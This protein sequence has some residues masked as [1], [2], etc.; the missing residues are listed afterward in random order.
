MSCD[1][2][3]DTSDTWGWWWS[4][5]ILSGQTKWAAQPPATRPVLVTSQTEP[6]RVTPSDSRRNRAPLAAALSRRAG[7]LAV[8][9][10]HRHSQHPKQGPG[11][12][13]NP[14]RSTGQHPGRRQPPARDPAPHRPAAHTR[15]FSSPSNADHRRQFL[16]LH[17]VFLDFQVCPSVSVS[18]ET[19]DTTRATVPVQGPNR[20][21]FT[22]AVSR[23]TL[24]I[25][26]L[27]TIRTPTISTRRPG[28]SRSF[29]EKQSARCRA[30]F[31]G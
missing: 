14:G 25:W 27:D 16:D 31:P 18:M 4:P 6:R 7:I 15:D 11:G 13:K 3:T 23:A 9:R 22:A 17:S 26:C 12:D 28:S 1:P 10:L 5:R 2:R 21:G 20:A 29:A 8:L 30:T 24:Y 19:C